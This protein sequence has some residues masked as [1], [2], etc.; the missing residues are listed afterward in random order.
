[1]KKLLSEKTYLAITILLFIL[2]VSMTLAVSI[3]PVKVSFTDVWSVILANVNILDMESLGVEPNIQ[4]IVLKLRLP[5]VILGAIVG[6]GLALSGVSMQAFTKNPLADPYVLGI[7]S[8][9]SAGAVLAV[10][11]SVFNVFGVFS[12]PI[13]AFIGALTSII[14]VYTLSKSKDG[15]LPIRLI[16]VGVAVS[17][18]FSALTNYVVFNAENEAGIRNATFWMMGGLAGT[19]WIYILVPGIALIASLIIMLIY[20]N[21]LNAMLM[22]ENTASVLGIDVKRVKNIIIVV[23]ALLTGSVV[24]VSGSIGFVGLIIPHVVRSFVGSNHIKVIPVAVLVGAIFLVWADVL[25]RVIVAP[26]DLPIG[27]ITA[28]CG[29]PFFIW[30]VKKNNY[31]FGD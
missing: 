24:A 18:L 12:I 4:N 30:L 14:L 22:G 15:V 3:G 23:S 17:S 7:S 29:A 21:S 27:I 6:G 13:G 1:M 26:S 2:L 9:A 5:R 11:T 20:S 10:L 28:L 25:A 19:K 16:L 8:G 31:S